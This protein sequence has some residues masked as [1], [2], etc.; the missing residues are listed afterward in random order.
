NKCYMCIT[1]ESYPTGDYEIESALKK[2]RISESAKNINDFKGS[3][4]RGFF[5]DDGFEVNMDIIPKPS[6]CISCIN[7][8]NPKEELLCNMTRNDQKDDQEFICFAYSSFK[9]ENGV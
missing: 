3:E 1:G 8:D 2:N 9:S 5:D 7:N 4:I 6:L